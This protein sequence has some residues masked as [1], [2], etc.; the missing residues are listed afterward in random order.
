MVDAMIAFVTC[1]SREEATKIAEALVENHLVACVNVIPAVESCY[2]WQGKTEWSSE[3]LLV[4]KTTGDAIGQ[5]H[6]KVVEEHSYEL[7]EFVAFTIDEGSAPYLQWIEN[8]V[9]PST[10]GGEKSEWE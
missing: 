9:A 2:R 8:S 3:F 1:G 10:P 4:L 5:A 7:P 6:E